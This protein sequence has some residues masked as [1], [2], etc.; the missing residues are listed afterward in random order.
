MNIGIIG[1]CANH[2]SGVR[3]ITELASA[4]TKLNHQ[5]TLYFNNRD[6]N[7]ETLKLL[8]E[9]QVD[10]VIVN[11]PF[12]LLRN[13]Q[14]NKHTVLT[15]HNH[16]FPTWFICRISG[17]PVVYTYYGLQYNAFSNALFPKKIP[18][19]PKFILDQFFNLIINLK[20]APLVF[21]SDKV[22]TISR[23]C[24]L[25]AQKIFHKKIDF[26][27]LAGGSTFTKIPNRSINKRFTILSV[28]RFT[29]YKGFH[30][31]T[32]VFKDFQKEF[33]KSQLIIAGSNGSRKYL[34]FLKSSKIKNLQFILN[35]SDRVLTRLYQKASVYISY[36]RY[37]F[38]GM[39]PLEAASFGKPLLLY[40]HAA[41]SELVTDGQNGF[42]YQTNTGLYL[43]L[44]LLATNPQLIKKMGEE[45]KKRASQ[46]NWQKTAEKYETI[47]QQITNQR[48]NWLAATSLVL[49]GVVIR[50]LFLNQHNIWFDEAITFFIAKLPFSNLLLAAAADNSPP[51]YALLLHF[52]V[53]LMPKSELIL[54]LPSFLFGL[55]SLYLVS[56]VLPFW[57]LK[58]S[59]PQILYLFLFS[60]FL[61]YLSSENR[62]YS[63]LLFLALLTLYLFYRFL[64][65]GQKKYFLFLSVSLI[66]FFYTH[67]FA[68]LY[69]PTLLTLIWQK[70]VYRKKLFEVIFAFMIALISFLPWLIFLKNIP[71]PLPYY[72][73]PL[74][75]TVGLFVATILGDLREPFFAKT[76]PVYYQILFLGILIYA[77]FI[78]IKA[79]IHY[80]AHLIILLAVFLP[81]LTLIL[82]SLFLPI[83]SIRPLII[84]L[85]FIYFFFSFGIT[86][87]R[88]QKLIVLG[89]LA[90]LLIQRFDNRFR[91]EQYKDASRFLNNNST[92]EVIIH[93]STLTYY[94]FRFYLPDHNHLLVGLNPL[95]EPLIRLIGGKT[96]KLSDLAPGNLVFVILENDKLPLVNSGYIS[97]AKYINWGLRIYEYQKQ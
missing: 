59:K 54:R 60:P 16:D 95:S 65:C 32:R 67:Y 74:K 80:S 36:D 50:T 29:P 14:K 42:L 77:A 66:L 34:D 94:P 18:K 22:I 45:A 3:A 88:S 28:S 70:K 97:K 17:I 1:S 69:I 31:L 5:I 30:H 83:F 23:Y 89:F 43:K 19:I 35:P 96:N 90:L 81:L 76:T 64:D 38:F 51:L 15:L 79:A 12:H 55:G 46:F 85:P 37:L 52:W 72:Y 56:K 53:K 73:Y 26:V 78:F 41:A 75:G 71:H 39:P 44:K 10:Y 20:A 91:F 8:R 84:F 4:L 49:L 33:P 40:N 82:I 7:G 27:Y 57:N 6:T 25:E 63:L 13:L 2:Y 21:L 11:N 47:F 86:N 58:P 87:N 62:N 92:Q 93:T 61:V 24:G 48:F 9:N 68:L